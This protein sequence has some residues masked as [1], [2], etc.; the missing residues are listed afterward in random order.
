MTQRVGALFLAVALWQARNQLIQRSNSL[1][2]RQRDNDRQRD[3][4]IAG[5]EHL[6][7]IR[8]SKTPSR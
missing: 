2:D 4:G 3:K 6:P 1:G 8:N 5:A 7:R